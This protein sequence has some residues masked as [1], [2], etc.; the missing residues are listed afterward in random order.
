MR[1]GPP[2]RSGTGPAAGLAGGRRSYALQ[3]ISEYLGSFTGGQVIDLGGAC[4]ST[5][6]YI[7]GLGHR[8]YSDDLLRSLPL[9]TAGN[10]GSAAVALDSIPDGCLEFPPASVDVIL[11][12]DRVQF[13]SESLSGALAERMHRIMAP[14]GMLLALFHA[15]Q[16]RTA[17]PLACRI[18]DGCHL[19]VSTRGAP[20]PLRPFNTRSI[21]RFFQ[22][23]E[24]LKF[25]LTR[26]N[27]QEV[28]VRR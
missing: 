20:R 22:R 26:E 4:Q 11:C 9:E 3:Q 19:H 8:L 24:S 10:A 14:G 6:D 18:A 12:W 16:I 5:I 15:E 13:L 25:Y 7:T 23:F 17:A 1:P 27:L 28:I 21:E 2:P